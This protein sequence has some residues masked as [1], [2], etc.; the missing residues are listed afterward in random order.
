MEMVELEQLSNEEVQE[1]FVL[2]KEHYHATDSNRAMSLL[3][4][5]EKEAKNFVKVMPTDYK[6]ALER[7][8]N[9]KK[10]KQTA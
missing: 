4:H 1:L 6:K 10:E 2:I 5:W 8:A 9:E 7:L 3:E